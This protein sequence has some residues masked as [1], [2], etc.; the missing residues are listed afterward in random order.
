MWQ[1]IL[2]VVALCGS[3]L[4]LAEQPELEVRNAWVRATAP[5][6]EMAAAY[7][8]L[9]S[10]IRLKLLAAKSSVA[11]SATLHWMAMQD[12]VMKMG[13]LHS[14]S[15]LANEPFELKPSGSHIMLGD[16]KKPLKAGDTVPLT[17]TFKRHDNS[18]FTVKVKA[19]VRTQDGSAPEQ[20][21]EHHHDH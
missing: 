3:Q 4:A 2:L 21:H 19:E 7:M 11:K 6:Q 20:Q 16:L 5:G 9:H 12:G 17:L 1:K 15:I 13:E 10:P 14:M 8:T 18:K